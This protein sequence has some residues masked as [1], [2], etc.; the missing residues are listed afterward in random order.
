MLN[1]EETIVVCVLQRR[2]GLIGELPADPTLEVITY[3]VFEVKP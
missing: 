3:E 2:V 1:E